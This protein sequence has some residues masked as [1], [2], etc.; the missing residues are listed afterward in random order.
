MIQRQ[1]NRPVRLC[2]PKTPKTKARWPQK[3]GLV[4]AV[5]AQKTHKGGTG[6]KATDQERKRAIRRVRAVIAQRAIVQTLKRASVIRR[7]TDQ[8]LKP[9]C[10]KRRPIGQTPRHEC[11]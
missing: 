1:T 10:A 11:V 3:S 6:P 9:E 5:R 7:L 4:R 8:T 2:W